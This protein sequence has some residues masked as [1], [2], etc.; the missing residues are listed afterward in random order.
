MSFARLA[1][2]PLVSLFTACASIPTKPIST[3]SQVDLNRFMGP[4]YVIASI[5]TFAEKHAFAAMESYE[6]NPD[7]SIA[8]TFTF[9]KG[10]LDGPLKT[11]KPTGFVRDSSNATWG[12]QF[13][14]PFKA[15]YLIAYVDPEYSETI[16][17][18]NKRDYVWIMARTPE[19]APEHYQHLVDVVGQLGYDLSK[20]KSVPQRVSNGATP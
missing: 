19:M 17:A 3:V 9:H 20:L 10:A 8:T 6:L 14:W 11:M 4:W 5:P 2:L 12:M 16:I 15:E 18:R 13:V 7:G 1:L